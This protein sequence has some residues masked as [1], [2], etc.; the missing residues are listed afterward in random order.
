MAS[1]RRLLT[2]SPL[3]AYGE[4]RLAVDRLDDERIAIGIVQTLSYSDHGF[5]SVALGTER[6]GMK[7]N[8]SIAYWWVLSSRSLRISIT[9]RFS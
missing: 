6:L 5:H 4:H 9:V 2:R 3:H 1:G 8:F 7:A